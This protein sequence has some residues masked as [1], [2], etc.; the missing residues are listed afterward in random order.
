MFNAKDHILTTIDQRLVYSLYLNISID[1]ID[2]C[3]QNP[4]SK[5]S[6]PLRVDKTPSVGFRWY[7]N[8]LI[9]RDFAK[10]E[11]RGDI[12]KIVGL[13]INENPMS[14]EGFKKI[15][16]DIYRTC[17]PKNRQ[18]L[19][20]EKQEMLNMFKER[21]KIKF[22]DRAL[23]SHDYKVF[24]KFGLKRHTVYSNIHSV[25]SYWLNDWRSPYRY[26]IGD[27][28]YAYE[29]NPNAIKLYFPYR[30]K[31]QR[32]FITDNHCPVECLHK[33]RIADFVIL[34][35][36]IKDMYLLNQIQSELG[37]N[38]ILIIPLASETSVVPADILNILRKNCN[39]KK[40]FALLDPDTTGI[41][42]MKKLKQD[43]DIEPMY[44]TAGFNS[45]DPTDMVADYGYNEVVKR[46][47][48]IIETM[49]YGYKTNDKTYSD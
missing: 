4:S 3:I 12:F 34:I 43:C 38:N 47:K 9:M 44:F 21:I 49:L 13:C 27:P 31:T 17:N 42:M 39:T 46:F 15:C 1:S 30:N 10:F 40:I 16:D 8:K 20:N 7:G 6:N 18:Y 23:N 11:Y 19:R 45:K 24:E 33:I 25:D 37:Y 2:Y 35:K 28:C 5:I 32:K 26:R 22:V 36:S 41:A 14:G 48:Y 29:V